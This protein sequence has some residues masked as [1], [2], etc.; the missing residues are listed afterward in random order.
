MPQQKKLED[1]YKT[2]IPKGP[3]PP[4]AYWSYFQKNPQAKTLPIGSEFKV[5]NQQYLSPYWVIK[6]GDRLSCIQDEDVT[7]KSFLKLSLKNKKPK[8]YLEQWKQAHVAG[9][10]LFLL[11]GKQTS[12]Q[13]TGFLHRGD[14]QELEEVKIS[15]HDDRFSK[16]FNCLQYHSTRGSLQNVISNK[17]LFINW[18][19]ENKE[20]PQDWKLFT[21]DTF[22]RTLLGRGAYG[23]V[24]QV[25]VSYDF[26][27][28]VPKKIDAPRAVKVQEDYCDDFPAIIRRSEDEKKLLRL[29][30]GA[31]AS[32]GVSYF[33]STIQPW[34][35][36]STFIEMLDCTGGQQKIGVPLFGLKIKNFADALQ[37]N[38]WILETL[39]QNF[40]NKNIIHY[41]LKRE[42]IILQR[43]NKRVYVVDL[44]HS[45]ESGEKIEG[46][47]GTFFCLAPEIW[48]SDYSFALDYFAYAALAAELFLCATG[49]DP[50]TVTAERTKILDNK[51]ATKTP[52]NFDTLFKNSDL[53]D[54][55]KRDIIKFLKEMGS[56][57]KSQRHSTN[58]AL[59][60]FQKQKI[61][62]Y[63]S[64]LNHL[65]MKALFRGFVRN[66][67]RIFEEL[68]DLK[69]TLFL[70]SNDI[71]AI[72][73]EV[74]ALNQQELNSCVADI[75]KPITDFLRELLQ[76]DFSEVSFKTTYQELME[77]TE[78]VRELNCLFDDLY[79]AVSKGYVFLLSDKLTEFTKTSSE[80]SFEDVN[81]FLN[82]VCQRD[83]QKLSLLSACF[84][85]GKELSAE[86]NLDEFLKK[87]GPENQ[88]SLLAGFFINPY[89]VVTQFK[90]EFA[91][92]KIAAD[93]LFDKDPDAE[94]S[95]KAAILKN[96]NDHAF[97]ERLAR[98][99]Y[100]LSL[101]DY[102]MVDLED[103]F[104]SLVAERNEIF[105]IRNELVESLE[106]MLSKK[107]EELNKDLTPEQQALKERIG[108][109]EN[110]SNPDTLYGFADKIRHNIIPLRQAHQ[111]YEEFLERHIAQPLMQKRNT[112]VCFLES[113]G[114]VINT[115]SKSI[116]GTNL[117]NTTRRRVAAK[118][119]PNLSIWKSASTFKGDDQPKSLYLY[120][121]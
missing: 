108:S 117:F 94:I 114:D 41:D 34:Q 75:Q 3:V 71:E 81:K 112:L 118:F 101:P 59:E 17:K 109:K 46:V 4:E 54:E 103:E 29:A 56:L 1:Q 13:L 90:Y 86:I 32:A 102:Y 63:A 8:H 19:I 26:N 87:L 76:P 95:L 6:F 65:I 33:N 36:S 96:V 48:D 91:S 40:H 70:D 49:G 15:R 24:L 58:E 14:A 68:D 115:F 23:R 20:G 31:Q 82:A 121:N 44:G 104:T 73:K 74:E 2:I 39:T 10:V 88:V 37:I 97:S 78:P 21:G 60:F 119:N 57:E 52:L 7:I 22:L 69:K 28:K 47:R 27:N 35:R 18:L 51:L 84:D 72:I 120:P 50:G 64:R 67:Q 61:H 53:D 83:Q 12:I 42:Q 25:V 89:V 55:I 16:F 43:G 11:T 98:F 100:K 93:S 45:K 66:T 62:Y 105:K 38:L 85:Q 92:V 110:P 5:N 106:T 80:F 9:A 107:L 111:Q 99:I 30:Y 77:K 79:N 113:V 116:L